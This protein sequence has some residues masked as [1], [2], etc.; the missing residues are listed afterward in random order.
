MRRKQIEKAIARIRLMEKRFDWLLSAW[1]A[2]DLS[3]YF[4]K[5][6]R[7]LT[8][9]YTCGQWLQD[10]TLDEAG[11]LP[12]D[13]KRGVLSQDA[14]YDFLSVFTQGEHTVD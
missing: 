3:P 1:K 13:L 9:Y 8:R 10:Y 5:E 11:L 6:L 4:Y 7:I 2:A 14:I 12:K